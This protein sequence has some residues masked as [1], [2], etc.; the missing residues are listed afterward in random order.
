VPSP[1]GVSFDPEAVVGLGVVPF[2]QA[3]S[4]TAHLPTVDPEQM[5]ETYLTGSA[6]TR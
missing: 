3:N 1:A 4:P 6:Q 2:A 5:F